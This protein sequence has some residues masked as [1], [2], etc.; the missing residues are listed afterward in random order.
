[1]KTTIRKSEKRLLGT[2][3]Q[4]R[5]KII[6][7]ITR[8]STNAETEFVARL[9]E[10]QAILYLIDGAKNPDLPVKLRISCAKDVIRF[11]R[12]PARIWLH[13]GNDINLM[14]PGRAGFPGATI[15]DEI[16][17]IEITRHLL[18]EI[19]HLIAAGVPTEIW[20]AA[21]LDPVL[22]LIE[23]YKMEA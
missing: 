5:K 1:M 9:S 18:C 14:A 12:G 4:R 15:G 20:P 21:I 19:E 23:H 13:N 10:L 8:R 17:A 6:K 7:G 22:G 2:R 16:A 11:A 3:Q